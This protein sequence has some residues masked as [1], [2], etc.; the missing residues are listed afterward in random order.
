V[1]P[2]FQKGR[3]DLKRKVKDAETAIINFKPEIANNPSNN[4]VHI[5]QNSKVLAIHNQLNDNAKEYQ[6][7][8]DIIEKE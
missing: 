1:V 3:Q 2:S 8:F 6:K 5:K 7:M 4:H